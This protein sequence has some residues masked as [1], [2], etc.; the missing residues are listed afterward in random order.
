MP[1]TTTATATILIDPGHGGF[2]GGTV[3]ADGTNEKHLNLAIALCLRDM[4]TVC[5]L[6]VSMT[7][8]CDEALHTTD[9]NYIRAKK[10]SDMRNR[11]SLYDNSTAVI[12]IHQNHFDIAKYSGSQVFYSPNHPDSEV[13]ASAVR[14]RVLTWLQPE[15][16]RELKKAT[17][18]I[19]LQYHTSVPSILVE[20]G[21]L[22]NQNELEK[23]KNAD[24]QQQ[25]AFAI[26]C[27]YLNYANTK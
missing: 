22:S 18:G 6:P 8:V 25:M 20:C 26:L 19:Y 2:D 17:D 5:G 9:D 14:D 4:M 12:S 21:F 23:L 3:A 27:G 15:N 7:R 16:T 11:L 10:V 13:L 24:Y 1:T